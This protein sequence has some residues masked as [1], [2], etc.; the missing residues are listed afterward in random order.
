MS[1]A[2]AGMLPRH[3]HCLNLAWVSCTDRRAGGACCAMLRH[4]VLCAELSGSQSSSQTRRCKVVIGWSHPLV[5]A[6][7]FAADRM[8][9]RL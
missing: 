9:R 2:R 4:R 8:P 5:L 7:P 3:L 1:A 6:F